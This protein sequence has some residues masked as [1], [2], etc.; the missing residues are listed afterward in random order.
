MTRLPRGRISNDSRSGRDAE[1]IIE[2]TAENARLRHALAHYADARN[3][4]NEREFRG[5]P[6]HHAAAVAVNAL[7][8][9]A[10]R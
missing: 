10:T 9:W 7:E 6:G 4:I 1:E 8:S 2:L 5:F 3:W